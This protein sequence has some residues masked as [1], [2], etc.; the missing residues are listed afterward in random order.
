MRVLTFALLVSYVVMPSIVSAQVSESNLDELYVG[1][2][3]APSILSVDYPNPEK[4][5]KASDV[6]FTWPLPEEVVAVAAEVVSE[7]NTE[8]MET[9]RP[10]VSSLSVKAG[11][12]NEGVQYLNVQFKNDEKWGPFA[13]YKV[14][15][16]NTAPESF[17]VQVA[18]HDGNQRGVIVSAET[19][20]ELSGLSHFELSVNGGSA[21]K[22]TVEEAQRGYFTHID[23]EGTQNIRMTAYDTAGN[24]R[25]ETTPVLSLPPVTIDPGVNPVG[26]VASEPASLLVALMAGLMLLTFGYLVYERQRYSI[27]VADL[28][29]EAEDIQTQMLRIFSA[30][31]EEIYDQIGAINKKTR[32]TKKEKEAVDGLSKA[33][34]VSEKLLEKEIKDVK[35]LLK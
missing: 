26:Y 9:F 22:M 4:W 12:W 10:P 20:D 29:R 5:Y 13:S 23:G 1:G 18:L 32:L 14:M 30:L 3:E 31:R 33:L 34:T 7:P 11:E 24:L 2:P 19:T 28:R 16:D 35:K 6:S 21:Q 15:I 25:S 27:A 8:P 17:S